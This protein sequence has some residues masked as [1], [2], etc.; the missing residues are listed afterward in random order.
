MGFIFLPMLLMQCFM[1]ALAMSQPNFTTD[2][3]ALLEFKAHITSDPL[4]IISSNWTSATSICNWVGVSC[5]ALHHRVTT[6]DLSNMSLTGSLPPQLGSLSF[7]VSLNLS[8]NNFH[9]HLPLEF[10]KLQ[11]LRLMDLSHNFLYGSI[12][13]DIWL[14]SKLE[15]FKVRD[16]QLTGT[17]SRNMVT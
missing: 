16:N 3:F 15:I 17:I 4:N 7:L 2:Q 9:G 13:G 1:A 12:P 14:L 10:G 8:R 5:G 11:R 6:L